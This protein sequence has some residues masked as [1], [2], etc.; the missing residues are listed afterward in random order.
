[1]ANQWQ[2]NLAGQALDKNTQEMLQR[3]M[4]QH[5]KNS[6]SPNLNT[7]ANKGTNSAANAI[8]ALRGNPSMHSNIVRQLQQLANA[9]PTSNSTSGQMNSANH[10]ASLH[11][12]MIK[13]EMV[14]LL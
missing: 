4:N 1:M 10:L 14:L 8:N 7:F 6:S 2:T 11:T 12:Q 5:K 13:Q 9:A 3:Y